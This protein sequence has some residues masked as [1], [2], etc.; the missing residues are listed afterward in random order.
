MDDWILFVGSYFWTKCFSFFK[1][2]LVFFPNPLYLHLLMLDAVRLLFKL[3]TKSNQEIIANRIHSGED[4]CEI[5]L[6]MAGPKIS[7]TPH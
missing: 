4:S 6:L 7:P 3:T 2:Q 1:V 5:Y